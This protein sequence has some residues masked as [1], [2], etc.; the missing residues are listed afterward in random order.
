MR[1]WRMRSRLSARPFGRE[2][3]GDNISKWAIKAYMV[4]YRN[5]SLTNLA[6]NLKS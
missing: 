1:L 6:L 2:K 4:L 3:D 5:S